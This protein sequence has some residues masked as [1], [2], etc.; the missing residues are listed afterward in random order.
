[1]IDLKS[2]ALEIIMI[3]LEIFSS[4]DNNDR[5]KIFSSRDNNDKT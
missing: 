1:M 3:R 5:L 4:G 2:S